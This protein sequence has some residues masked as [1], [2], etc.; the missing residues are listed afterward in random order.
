MRKLNRREFVAR[1]GARG[2]GR[3]RF[4]C[5]GPQ[6]VGLSNAQD[7]R[8]MLL[9]HPCPVSAGRPE[10]RHIKLDTSEFFTIF[11]YRSR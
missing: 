1:A 8:D 5:Q 4:R 2:L 6:T 10:R 9:A 3:S 11:L 7:L